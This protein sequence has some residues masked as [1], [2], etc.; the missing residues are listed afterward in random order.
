MSTTPDRE[1]WGLMLE[2]LFSHHRPRVW[3]IASEFDLTPMQM[4]A[5]KALEPGRTLPMSALADSLHCDASNVT[6]IVDRLES[7]G[8][9]ERR[10][11]PEDR[12]VK[13]LAVT[14]AGHRLRE[15]IANRMNEP[16]PPIAELSAQDQRGLRDILGR[17]LRP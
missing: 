3:G 5:L 11:S 2:L 7:R 1:A 13:M 16:P 10:G 8:L 17:A 4:L 14:E 6:G 9:I 15:Q 12:R